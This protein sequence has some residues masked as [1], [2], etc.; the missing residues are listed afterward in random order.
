MHVADMS[1]EEKQYHGIT[2][3]LMKAKTWDEVKI[4]EE[5]LSKFE[6]KHPDIV[7]EIRSRRWI[8]YGDGSE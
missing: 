3:K 8:N 7:D 6:K 2:G 5:E 4:V 1:E